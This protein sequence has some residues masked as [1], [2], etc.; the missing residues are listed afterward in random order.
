MHEKPRIWD[1]FITRRHR[2]NRA[3][4]CKILNEFSKRIGRNQYEAGWNQQKG[5]TNSAK[6]LMKSVRK[7]DGFSYWMNSAKG[8]DEIVKVWTKSVVVIRL[9]EINTKFGRNQWN[10]G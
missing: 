3:G 4:N 6:A 2:M 8:L 9:H 10:V 5:W 7:M 1:N